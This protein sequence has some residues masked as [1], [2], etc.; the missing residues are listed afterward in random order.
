MNNNIIESIKSALASN[1]SG[2]AGLGCRSA[3]K[4]S[5][6]ILL[7]ADD[8]KDAVDMINSCIRDL[9]HEMK[10]TKASSLK[11]YQIAKINTY[12]DVLGMLTGEGGE[13]V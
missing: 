11:E 1:L 12:K 3:L 4:S 6:E 7:I 5:E 13:L 9:K 10:F 2:N 8:S